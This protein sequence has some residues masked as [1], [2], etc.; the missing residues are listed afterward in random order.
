[1][2]RLLEESA[3]VRGRLGLGLGLGLGSGRL[4]EE[5]AGALE[6]LWVTSVLVG[7]AGGH[8]R[9]EVE[10]SAAPLVAHVRLCLLRARLECIA[11]REDQAQLVRL[12]AC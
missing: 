12:E 9:G 3:G 4:L 7:G 6:P 11:P 8:E 10:E 2:R 1:M 5:S